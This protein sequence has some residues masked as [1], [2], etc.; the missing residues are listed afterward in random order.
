MSARMVVFGF[1]AFGEERIN[2]S[3]VAVRALHGRTLGGVELVGSVLPVTYANA[4]STLRP[5]LDAVRPVAV[6]GVGQG[7]ERFQVES[8]A[9]NVVGG[10]PDNQ[11][12]SVG[13]QVQEGGRD[14]IPVTADAAALV[15]TLQGVLADAGSTLAGLLS[16]DAGSYLCNHTLYHVLTW[17]DGRMPCAFVHVPKLK[18]A[19][20]ALINRVVEAVAGAMVLQTRRAI[21]A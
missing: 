15:D 18:V 7:G 3:E 16:Q 8:Q 12:R 5:V 21:V 6:M 19:E 10:K 13:G 1:E 20:Q 2:P 17:A 11:G 4:F 14:V 9:R